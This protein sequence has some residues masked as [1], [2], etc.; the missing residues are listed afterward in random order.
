MVHSE[1]ILKKIISCLHRGFLIFLKRKKVTFNTTQRG[2]EGMR[3]RLLLVTKI[4]PPQI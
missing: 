1:K 4:T 2:S 3:V